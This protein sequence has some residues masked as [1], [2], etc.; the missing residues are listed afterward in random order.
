VLRVFHVNVELVVSKLS[1]SVVVLEG[2]EGFAY[3]DVALRIE[4]INYENAD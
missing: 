2:I 1:D 3:I 4:Y